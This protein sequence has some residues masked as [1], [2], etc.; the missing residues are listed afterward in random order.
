[1][2]AHHRYRDDHH[3]LPHGFLIQNTQKRDVCTINLKLNELIQAIGSAGN[4]MIDIERLSDAELNI[5]ARRY[6]VIRTEVS[7]STNSP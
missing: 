5:L 1:M 7:G 3:Y 4:Q 6:E 2:A